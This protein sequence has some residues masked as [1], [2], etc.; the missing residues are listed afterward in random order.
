M[1][2]IEELMECIR[3]VIAGDNRI[4]RHSLLPGESERPVSNSTVESILQEIDHAQAK[5]PRQVFKKTQ[6]LPLGD[7]GN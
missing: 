6:Q 1:E 7:A 4:E 3:Q 5:I 2:P